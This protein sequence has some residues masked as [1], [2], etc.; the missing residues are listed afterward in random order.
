MAPLWEAGAQQ[1]TA[2]RP[3][4]VDVTWFA[5]K[6]FAALLDLASAQWPPQRYDGFQ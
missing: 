3:V 6:H 4:D 1:G 2:E 5:S